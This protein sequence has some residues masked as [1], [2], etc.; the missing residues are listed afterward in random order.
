ML[1]PEADSPNPR[2]RQFHRVIR[3]NAAFNAYVAGA[4][5]HADMTEACAYYAKEMKAIM[6]EGE[7]N[8][9]TKRKSDGEVG[10]ESAAKRAKVPEAPAPAP[11]DAE[12]EEKEETADLSTQ[13]VGEENEDTVFEARAKAFTMV[14]GKEKVQ[15]V[16]QLRVLKHRE[17][18]VVRVLMRQDMSGRLALNAGL[19]DKVKYEVANKKHVVF[20]VLSEGGKLEKWWIRVKLEEEATRLAEV[21]EEE[22]ARKGGN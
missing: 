2:P 20:P 7:V 8:R 19:L 21:L 5:A 14:D 4:K 6:A 13:R 15:G 17:T 12:E 3:L 16:G 11:S 22:K 10:G 18:G 1:S 9:T